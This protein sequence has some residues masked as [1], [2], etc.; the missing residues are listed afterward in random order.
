MTIDVPATAARLTA[1]EHTI[2][3]LTAEAK[4]LR[5]TLVDAVETGGT[6]T[7]PDGTPLYRVAPGRRTFKPQLAQQLI[8]DQAILDACTRT[9]IDGAAVKRLS[10]ALWEQCCTQGE[11]FLTRAGA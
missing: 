3:N 4:R 9:A 7:T 8:T 10:P 5:Q 6:I 1:I 11:P 2:D